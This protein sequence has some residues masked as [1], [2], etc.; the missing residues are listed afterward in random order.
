MADAASPLRDQDDDERMSAPA[1]DTAARHLDRL[2]P[3][4]GNDGER[5]QDNEHDGDEDQDQDDDDDDDEGID[6]RPGAGSPGD[7]SEEEETDSEEEREIRKGQAQASPATT[8][9]NRSAPLLRPA[10]PRPRSALRGPRV[11]SPPG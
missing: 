2:A 11:V 7:S 9:P 8:L 5:A 4:R 3:D 6:L 10:T 1:P